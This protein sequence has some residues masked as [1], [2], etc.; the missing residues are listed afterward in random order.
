MTPARRVNDGLTRATTGVGSWRRGYARIATAGDVIVVTG[1]PG[2]GRSTVHYAVLLP[3]LDVGIER[4]T[5]RHGH[6]FTDRDATTH[7]RHHFDGPT[8]ITVTC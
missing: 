6:G 7:L 1:P 5:K 8:S 2:A 4:V 3:P